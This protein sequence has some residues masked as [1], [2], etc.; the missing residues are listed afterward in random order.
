MD[1]IH[2]KKIGYAKKKYSPFMKFFQ[3]IL[4]QENSYFG[5]EPLN[6]ADANLETWRR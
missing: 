1:T 5:N 2:N 3:R 4:K 6:I